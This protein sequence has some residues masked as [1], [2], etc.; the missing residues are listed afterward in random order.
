MESIN[1]FVS[2]YDQNKAKA[3][4][5]RYITNDTI[6]PLLKVLPN[7]FKFEIIGRSEQ[8]RPIYS[9]KIGAGKTKILIWSQM[10]GNESTCTKALFDV[11]NVLTTA[12]FNTILQE[13][14][15]FII[16]ILNPDGA[17][18]YTR[19]NSNQVDI[20]RDAVD[21]SQAESK[22]LRT[23]FDAFKPDYGFN[24]HDQRTLFN[25]GQNN[26]PATVSFLSPAQDKA[27]TLTSNRLRAMSVIHQMNALLQNYI[28]GQVGRFDDAF[29]IN[30]VGDYFQTQGAS[31]ILFEAGHYQND[32]C[33]E[34]SRKFIALATL[35]ALL[36]IS[37]NSVNENDHENYFQIPENNTLFFDVLIKN[38][39]ISND[40]KESVYDIG[41][42]YEE[43]LKD[44]EVLF[45]PKIK[46]IGDLSSYF[47]HKIINAEK[48][49][50]KEVNGSKVEINAEFYDIFIG[51]VKF[52]L[53]LNNNLA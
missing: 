4:S 3:L 51:G 31:T 9:I 46:S 20:N 18:A 13:C 17:A 12:P 40:S 35:Q 1:D 38:A 33:R 41:I 53:F 10:H 23:V 49:I 48:K 21:L 39:L 22:V 45:V 11:F 15:L 27:L 44:E 6:L 32:Y 47:G 8:N 24:M 26:V 28:P 5:G 50:L 19:H 42:S 29:N 25:V 43:I 30:C 16:P 34:K 2:N 14:S 52:S 7:A 36:C 37:A